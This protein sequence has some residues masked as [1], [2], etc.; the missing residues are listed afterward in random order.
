MHRHVSRGAIHDLH[1]ECN[2]SS[3]SPWTNE[4]NTCAWQRKQNFERIEM[5]GWFFWHQL[6]GQWRSMSRQTKCPALLFSTRSWTRNTHTQTHTH[7]HTHTFHANWNAT[8]DFLTQI[9][10][11]GGGGGNSSSN[12]SHWHARVFHTSSGTLKTN[13]RQIWMTCAVFWHMIRCDILVYHKFRKKQVLEVSNLQQQMNEHI[14]IIVSTIIT[15]WVGSDG[16]HRI[17]NSH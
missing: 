2:E 8:R 4:L 10:W 15:L 3:A 16:L 9:G 11:G 17:V 1:R 7:T 13:V 12:E 14:L 5:P 6:V